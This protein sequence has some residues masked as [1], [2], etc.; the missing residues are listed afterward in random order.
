MRQSALPLNNMKKI[1]AG[2]VA[3]V[4]LPIVSLNY[5]SASAAPVVDST[6]QVEDTS[7]VADFVN[8]V[9][10]LSP[11]ANEI[12]Q[13]MPRNIGI[14]WERVGD[15]TDYEVELGCKNCG[16]TTPWAVSMVKK[17]HYYT[18]WITPAVSQDGEY[19]VRVRGVTSNGLVGPWSDYRYFTYDTSPVVYV[20]ARKRD[21]ALIPPQVLTPAVNEKFRNAEVID[22]AWEPLGEAL[23][24]EVEV[25]CHR[26][27]GSQEWQTSFYN[28]LDTSLQAVKLPAKREYRFR[29]RATDVKGKVGIWSQYRNF[30]TN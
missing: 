16:N 1:L 19:R 30:Q 14:G 11:K 27:N 9:T 28:T 24:Y 13:N 4:S 18:H 20:Q 12:L 22:L 26:C 17:M 8:K 15:A 10:I 6:I 23:K 21:F 29:V 25:A 7:N 5:F 3:V 2:L